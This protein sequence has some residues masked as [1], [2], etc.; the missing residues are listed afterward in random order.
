MP[1]RD[2]DAPEAEP[3]LVPD[4]EEPKDLMTMRSKPWTVRIVRWPCDTSAELGYLHRRLIDVQM[5]A[6]SLRPPPDAAR[7]EVLD[8][9]YALPAREPD[10]GLG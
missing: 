4:L 3:W 2:D 6:R 7:P 10:H 8:A 9:I 5:D 1:A